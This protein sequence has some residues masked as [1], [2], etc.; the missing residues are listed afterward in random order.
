MIAEVFRPWQDVEVRW[1]AAGAGRTQV[2]WTIHY[3]RGLDPAWYFGPL[4][5]YAVGFAAQYLIDAVATP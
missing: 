3:R 5:R 4:E 2:M 1:D